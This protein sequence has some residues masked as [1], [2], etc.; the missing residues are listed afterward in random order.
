[1]MPRLLAFAFAAVLL[2]TLGVA[3]VAAPD[4]KPADAE[5]KKKVVVKYAS[6]VSQKTDGVVRVSNLKEAEVYQDDAVF[7]SDTMVVRSEKDVHEFT[8]TG[9]PVF[10]D[11]ESR[12]TS[13]KVVAY[14]SPRR[15]Q[16]TGNVKMVNTPKPKK[17]TKD[18]SNDMKN[19]LRNAPSTTTCNEMDY[20]YANKT[21]LAKGN[22]VVVQKK[23][24][25]WADQAVYNQKAELI[26]L[27]GNVRMEN[28]GDDELKKLSDADIVTVSLENDW[29]DVRPAAGKK[30][31]M[32]LEVSEDEKPA[33]KK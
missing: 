22:V 32:E 8:C 23:R 20:D 7:V 31:V 4:A 29:I 26:T 9:N 5:K 15:A 6:L 11:P 30:A 27:S 25:L 24:T 33:G 28:T 1:M 16:F 19:E 18:G 21:A 14:S 2:C 12:V 17:G 13:D 3:L 10:T